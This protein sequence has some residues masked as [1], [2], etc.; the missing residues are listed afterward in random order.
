[1]TQQ[2]SDDGVYQASPVRGGHYVY[3]EAPGISRAAIA[4]SPRDGALEIAEALERYAR[5]LREAAR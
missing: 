1:M 5:A 4:E 2:I 3:F